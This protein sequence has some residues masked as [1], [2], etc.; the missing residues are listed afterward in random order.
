[1][2]KINIISSHLCGFSLIIL[3]FDG[4]LLQEEE[5][6]KD[7]LMLAKVAKIKKLHDSSEK[8]DVVYWL[9]KTPAERIE[10]VEFLR[11][12][13]YNEP[14]PRLQRVARIVKRK[15]C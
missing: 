11:K 8:D 5:K 3:S 15:S 12:Q 7:S 6:Q 9:S 4:N 1:M 10:A 14:A 2:F 13:M